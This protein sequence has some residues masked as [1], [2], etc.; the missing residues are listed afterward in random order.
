MTRIRSLIQSSAIAITLATVPAFLG[1]CGGA[2]SY[3]APG[4]GPAAGSDVNIEVEDTDMGNRK[5][6]VEIDHLPPPERVAEGTS[7]FAVWVTADDGSPQRLGTLQYDEDDRK[8]VCIGNTPLES[9]S[10]IV[11]AEESESVTEPSEHIV[12]KHEDLE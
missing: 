1:G 8:G 9:F 6:T 11:T 7:V 12:V 4:V 5:V 10:L 3:T 2:N